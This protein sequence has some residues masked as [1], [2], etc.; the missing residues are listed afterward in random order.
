[1][2]LVV[3]QKIFRGLA[4]V[5]DVPESRF[6]LEAQ[7]GNKG[8]CPSFLLFQRRVSHFRR[9]MPR[10]FHHNVAKDAHAEWWADH[11][12]ARRP[13]FVPGPSSPGFGYLCGITHEH[14]STRDKECS[15][16]HQSDILLLTDLLFR[17]LPVL[18][19]KHSSSEGLVGST[20]LTI[21]KPEIAALSHIAL[22]QGPLQGEG[23]GSENVDSPSTPPLS[24]TRAPRPASRESC[25]DGGGEHNGAKSAAPECIACTMHS[26]ACTTLKCLQPPPS[27]P[28]LWPKATGKGSPPP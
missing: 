15:I 28:I 13:Y 2:K 14:L 21:D 3:D 5:A 18:S 25:G 10:I 17:Q 4:H 9:C 22:L 26:I 24:P 19:P 12:Q 1:M 11:W 27:P 7:V 8:D 20:L 16:S 6:I 23:K